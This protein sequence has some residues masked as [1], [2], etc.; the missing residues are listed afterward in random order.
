MGSEERRRAEQCDSPAEVFAHPESIV[1]AGRVGAPAMN[2]VP[3]EVVS[4]GGETT[5]RSADGWS[6]G[7][8]PENGRRA[9]LSSSPRVILGARHFQRHGAA[10]AGAHLIRERQ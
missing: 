1:V 5:L 10:G 8:N 2:P 7:L 4:T 6:L 9:Q 3:L